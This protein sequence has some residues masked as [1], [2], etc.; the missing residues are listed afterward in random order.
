[1]TRELRIITV[2]YR[3]I[4]WQIFREEVA[5]PYPPKVLAPPRTIGMSVQARNSDN[6][7]VKVSKVTSV[8]REIVS[9]SV[10]IR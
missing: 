6:T 3:L 2:N 10:V 1:M 5:E 8:N 4:V 9:Y 7:V